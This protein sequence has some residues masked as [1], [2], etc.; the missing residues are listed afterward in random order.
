MCRPLFS[1][2]YPSPHT[3]IMHTSSTL[4]ESKLKFNVYNSLTKLVISLLLKNAV[5][6]ILCAI[7]N[8]YDNVPTKNFNLLKKKKKE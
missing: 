1:P 7:T 2:P 4:P 6:C 3:C 8:C 5:F